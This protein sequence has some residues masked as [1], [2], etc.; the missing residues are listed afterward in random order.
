MSALSLSLSSLIFFRT[1]INLVER[2]S[3]FFF[4]KSTSYCKLTFFISKNSSAGWGFEYLFKGSN[5]LTFWFKTLFFL[6]RCSFLSLSSLSS[7]LRSL[8][9]SFKSF[10]L[11]C[12]LRDEIASCS[13]WAELDLFTLLRG[14]EPY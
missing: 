11:F 4:Q 7:S 10:I 13:F 3:H 8:S 9:S 6:E 14:I 12:F 5:Y 2:S 1:P